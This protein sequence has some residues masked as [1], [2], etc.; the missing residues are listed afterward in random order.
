MRSFVTGHAQFIAVGSE[1]SDAEA[2]SSGVPQG[3]V[4]GP[5]LSG[6]YVS[7]VGDVI[8]QHNV[9]YHQYADDLQMYMSLTP[10]PNR[11]CELSTIELC[12]RDVSRWFTENALLL[13]PA[14][15]E[16]VFFG[17]RQRQRLSQLNTSHGINVAGTHIQFTDAVKLLGVTLDS[18]LSFDNM[19]LTSH[20]SV[21]ITR[22]H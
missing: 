4:L 1:R 9:S 14:K 22:G 8:M 16:A 5:I 7:P 21:I 19:S 6:M 11:S 20:A 18:T 17:T 15:T 13:N 10:T 12:A 3:S 2:C